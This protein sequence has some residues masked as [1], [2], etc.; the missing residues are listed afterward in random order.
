MLGDCGL[1]R[2][3]PPRCLQRLDTVYLNPAQ[4]NDNEPFSTDFCRLT[5]SLGILLFA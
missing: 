3:V 1:A 4:T 5:A 2:A